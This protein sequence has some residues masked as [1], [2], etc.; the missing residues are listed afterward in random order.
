MTENTDILT[1]NIEILVRPSE[2]L[3]EIGK[4]A[5]SRV[6]FRTFLINLVNRL[7]KAL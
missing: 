1:P 7:N 5:S 6:L 2:R 4:N 3:S